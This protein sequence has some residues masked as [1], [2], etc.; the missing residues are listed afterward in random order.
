MRTGRT[1]AAV[2]APPI[3]FA[4]MVATACGTGGVGAPSTGS[5][6]SSI[7]MSTSPSPVPTSARAPDPALEIRDADGR[8]PLVV[9]TKSRDTDAARRLILAGADVNAKDNLQD[10]AFLYAGAEGLDD[11]LVLTLDHGADVNSTNRFGG[12]A[13]IPAAEKGHP[14]TVQILID[15]GVPL[16]HINDSGWTA[17]LE[18]VVYGD[19]SPV[20]QEIVSRLLAAGADPGIRD[21]QGRTALQIAQQRGQADVARLLG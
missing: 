2:A 4:L 21:S 9:A 20:Y 8:T 10:S 15:A 18:A 1:P 17:L 6:P 12:T 16:D 14:T 3:A 13:L 5:S 19:G 11:I 7:T